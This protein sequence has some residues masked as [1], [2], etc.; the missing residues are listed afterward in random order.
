MDY[1]TFGRIAT[2]LQQ[3]RLMLAQDE[4][5]RKLLVAENPSSAATPTVEQTLGHI[6]LQP[7]VEV[8]TKPPFDKKAFLSLVV[9][10]AEPRDNTH[11]VS[12]RVNV[13]VDKTYWVYGGNKI[14]ILE[15]AERVA[16]VLDKQKFACASPLFY[17]SI[18]ETVTNS[19]VFGYVM[20]FNVADGIGVADDNK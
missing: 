11:R 6:F 10:E 17:D 13:L 16:K 5:L 8:E 7:I 3:A 15:M 19:Y 18:T 14:R 4:Q 1:G 2:T 12:I 9:A 20:L